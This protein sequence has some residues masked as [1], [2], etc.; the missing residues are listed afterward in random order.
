MSGHYRG[1][2]GRPWESTQRRRNLSQVQSVEDPPEAARNVK[3]SNILSRELALAKTFPSV[4]RGSR[5]FN[6]TT[7]WLWSLHENMPCRSKLSISSSWIGSQSVQSP[8][9]ETR[10][11]DLSSSSSLTAPVRKK[12][13][14]FFRSENIARA[15]K[16]NSMFS[17]CWYVRSSSPVGRNS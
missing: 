12:A 6:V 15:E 9:V 13:P 5:S 2:Q 7:G 4:V 11:S 3:S 8:L 14:C 1:M 17:G 10:T 16:L